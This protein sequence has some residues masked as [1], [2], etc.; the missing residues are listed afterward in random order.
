MPL[1]TVEQYLDSLRK[2]K[3]LAFVLGEEIAN[4]VDHLMIRPPINAAAEAYRLAEEPQY[5]DLI[6]TTCPYTKKEINRFTHVSRSCDDKAGTSSL[7]STAEPPG[8]L[9]GWSSC[10]KRIGRRSPV[11]PEP[12][13][14][15]NK[16]LFFLIDP[17]GGGIHGGRRAAVSGKFHL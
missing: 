8:P 14:E 11:W 13:P 6:V 12:W 3:P 7:T 4:P 9:T 15:S 2:M 10:A 5:R 17:E 16:R 1:K